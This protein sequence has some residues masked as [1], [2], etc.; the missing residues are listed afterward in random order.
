VKGVKMAIK[1]GQVEVMLRDLEAKG[2]GKEGEAAIG[3]A[4]LAV[5]EQLALMTGTLNKLAN[6]GISK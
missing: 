2:R 3:W 6:Q 5:A 1:L 4:I